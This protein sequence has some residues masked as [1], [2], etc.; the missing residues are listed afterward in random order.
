VQQRRLPGLL[1]LA[2]PLLQRKMLEV[3]QVPIVFTSVYHS[4][5]CSLWEALH[6]LHAIGY[7]GFEYRH[8]RT[9]ENWLEYITEPGFHATPLW[10]V[11]QNAY[12]SAVMPPSLDADAETV[13]GRA[14]RL[15][16][17]HKLTIGREPAAAAA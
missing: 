3:G 16:G 9:L 12:D 4:P 11:H 17:A 14:P 7:R 2:R 1:G 8:G 6:W 10:L 5:E 13:F 15:A